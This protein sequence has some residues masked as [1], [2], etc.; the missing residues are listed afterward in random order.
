[1]NINS[2]CSARWMSESWSKLKVLLHVC[3]ICMWL[4][5]VA[6]PLCHLAWWQLTRALV[7]RCCKND[8]SDWSVAFLCFIS[9]PILDAAS[10]LRHLAKALDLWNNYP[11]K[12]S[13]LSKL[14]CSE[15][16]VRVWLVLTCV[17]HAMSA[18]YHSIA[19]KKL[20]DSFWS[21]LPQTA[22]EFGKDCQQR[23]SAAHLPIYLYETQ[24]VRLGSSNHSNLS[25][26]E[27]CLTISW[28]S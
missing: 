3:R 11:E 8:N 28:L 20:F 17:D 12:W 2:P 4:Q 25:G 16:M 9:F 5:R 6:M 18:L 14:E 27:L 19:S 7:P 1:M 13:S 15:D 22:G 10:S 23:N 24:S 26:W 21:T